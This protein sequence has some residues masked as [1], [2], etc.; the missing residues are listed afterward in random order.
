MYWHTCSMLD[1]IGNHTG[2]TLTTRNLE[3]QLHSLVE[4]GE[5]ILDVDCRIVEWSGTVLLDPIYSIDV[6]DHEGNCEHISGLRNAD[7]HYLH[8]ID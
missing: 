7:C 6:K 3:K 5:I 2:V 4:G 1:Q 8:Q